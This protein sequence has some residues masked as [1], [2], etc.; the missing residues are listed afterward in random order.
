[1]DSFGSRLRK[2]IER[3][4]KTQKVFAE[5]IGFSAKSVSEWV[6]DN[7]RP[8]IDDLPEIC[9]MLQT[10]SDYLLGIS[11]T[12]N[13]H[14][15][16]Q[17]AKSPDELSDPKDVIRWTEASQDWI[18]DVQQ[19]EMEDGIRFFRLRFQEGMTSEWVI[20]KLE[21]EYVNRDYWRSVCKNVLRA[22]VIK[23]THVARDSELE[24]QII[25]HYQDF[26]IRTVIVADVPAHY[27]ITL[28]WAEIV[29][30]LAAKHALSAING[31]RYI[32][33]GSGYTLTRMS[34]ISPPSVS[35]FSGTYW[36]PLMTPSLMPENI[37]N[38]YT[39]NYICSHLAN[40]HSG[41]QFQIFP[42]KH[43]KSD[44]YEAEFAKLSEQYFSNLQSVF[45]SVNGVGRQK[46]GVQHLQ[47]EFRSADRY[48]DA[49]II[50]QEYARNNNR[51]N[52]AGEILGYL[53]N[54]DG[55]V[56]SQLGH[57]HAVD[58]EQLRFC[59]AYTGKVWIVAARK[60]KAN[61][62]LAAIKSGL[63]NC[64]VIDQEIAKFLIDTSKS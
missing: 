8:R 17:K 12:P 60:Y 34:E 40:K 30:F 14:S 41:S 50:R 28:T 52:I 59:N 27:G 2:L 51:E 33:L 49:P 1:M 46:T 4:F 32:G 38:V 56:I 35:Q 26:N 64:L 24:G 61:A 31:E 63:A 18:S 10:S 62:V 48:I 47:N 25:E 13:A 6:R 20:K 11:D 16:N 5:A 57:F 36:I 42:E 39:A 43:K 9:R 45:V 15:V 37:P 22:G 53:I 23:I 44:H 19:K 29:A 21:G 3:H 58:L 55:S 54:R 7:H